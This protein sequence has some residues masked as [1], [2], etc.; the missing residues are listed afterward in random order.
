MSN[1]IGPADLI[2]FH[3]GPKNSDFK[4]WKHAPL[5]AIVEQTAEMKAEL[6]ASEAHAEKLKA[7]NDAAMAANP[8]FNNPTGETNTMVMTNVATLATSDIK[9]RIEYITNLIRSG[10]ANNYTFQSGNGEQTTSSIHQYLYWLQQ[11]AQELDD[12]TYSPVIVLSR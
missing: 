1:P 10:E 7:D 2:K 5:S 6:A 11:R 8:I 4:N 9:P 12:G 3:S